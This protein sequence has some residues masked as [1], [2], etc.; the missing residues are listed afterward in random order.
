MTKEE[1]RLYFHEND[2]IEEK[3]ESILFECKQLLINR[4]PTT[5]LFRS[6]IQRLKLNSDAYKAL[7]GQEVTFTPRT[8]KV[9]RYLSNQVSETVTEFYLES[10]RLK[11]QLFNS[12]SFV[13]LKYN[14][15]QL[16]LNLKGFA[17]KWVISLDGIEVEDVKI[18]TIPNPMNV[19]SAVELFNQEGFKYFNEI[20]INEHDNLLVKESIRL[21]LWLKFEENV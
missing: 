18:S 1:A 12:N 10:N 16:I 5:K 8:E 6:S 2:D 14:C 11:L 20:N 3:Y 9:N 17:L 4:L 19:L 15:N 21:S 13:E 7:G